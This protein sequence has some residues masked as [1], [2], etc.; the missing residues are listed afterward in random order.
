M[1]ESKMQAEPKTTPEATAS[2]SNSKDQNKSN[3]DK[4]PFK[5]L[6]ELF[7]LDNT[8]RM[9]STG[10]SS[11]Q[12]YVSAIGIFHEKYARDTLPLT[13]LPPWATL[14]P[15]PTTFSTPMTT[16]SGASPPV[17]GVD[18]HGIGMP[19]PPPPLPPFG[20]VPHP[21]LPGYPM[22]PPPGN[23]PVC[24]PGL[25]PTVKQERI[26]DENFNDVGMKQM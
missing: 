20:F 23:M 2:D 21:Y 8:L 15:P 7:W 12:L 17:H 14:M 19:P 9:N 18:P 3:D 24:P 11:M 13:H 16:Y 10:R 26:A 1:S 22:G 25:E 4:D 6:G 5:N